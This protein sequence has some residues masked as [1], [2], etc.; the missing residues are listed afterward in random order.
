[1]IVDHPKR[2]TNRSRA[3]KVLDDQQQDEIEQQTRPVC[4]STASTFD[5]NNDKPL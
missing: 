2:T 1:M 3:T 4:E 5:F